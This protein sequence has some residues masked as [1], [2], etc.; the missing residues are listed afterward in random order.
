VGTSRV[1]NGQIAINVDT[2][3]LNKHDDALKR[4][5]KQL[6]NRLPGFVQHCDVTEAYS[7]AVGKSITGSGA[8]WS[9]TL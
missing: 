8:Y 3:A 5:W 6:E 9:A 1:V 7:G 2:H 4:Q